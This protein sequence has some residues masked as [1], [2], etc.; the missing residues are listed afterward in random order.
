[1]STRSA[2]Q[3]MT[4]RE[5][6]QGDAEGWGSEFC[7][8]LGLADRWIRHGCGD[9]SLLQFHLRLTLPKQRLFR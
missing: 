7:E 6:C 3:V 1:M 5:K 9:Y 2:N 4:G 8:V